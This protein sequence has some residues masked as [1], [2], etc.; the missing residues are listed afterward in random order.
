MEAICHDLVP[1]H[2]GGLPV[3]IKKMNTRLSC[4]TNTSM[5]VTLAEEFVQTTYHL[6]SCHALGTETVCCAVQAVFG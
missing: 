1:L 5:K 2:E 6:R 3:M 4:V